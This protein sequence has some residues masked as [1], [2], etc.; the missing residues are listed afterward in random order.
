VDPTGLRSSAVPTT[1]MDRKQFFGKL[2][3][4]DEEHLQKVLWN[5]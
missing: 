3:K 5:L 2:A 4:V 1:R